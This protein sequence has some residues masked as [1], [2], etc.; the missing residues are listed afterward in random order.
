[1]EKGGGGVAIVH[2]ATNST[3]LI[4]GAENASLPGH[5]LERNVLF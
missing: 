4:I 5:T 1:M 2:R 3:L